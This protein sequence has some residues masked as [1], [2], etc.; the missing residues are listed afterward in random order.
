MKPREHIGDTRAVPPGY[1]RRRH[2][3]QVTDPDMGALTGS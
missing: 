3:L 2:I 1:V